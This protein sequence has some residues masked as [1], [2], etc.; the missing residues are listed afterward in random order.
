MRHLARWRIAARARPLVPVLWERS[1]QRE[2]PSSRRLEQANN[3]LKHIRA[4]RGLDAPIRAQLSG[5][6]GGPVPVLVAEMTDEQLEA[7]IQAE[8]ARLALPI[9]STPLALPT[10]EEQQRQENEASRANKPDSAP[11]PA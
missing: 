7:F 2:N 3:T 6:G 1:K 11:S 8:Q 9:Q 5:P 10:A 4:L